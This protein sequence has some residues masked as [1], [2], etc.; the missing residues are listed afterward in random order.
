MLSV[1]VV[2]Q[3]KVLRIFFVVEDVILDKHKDKL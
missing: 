1:I 2:L 3:A